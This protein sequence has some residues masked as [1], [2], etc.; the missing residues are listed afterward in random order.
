MESVSAFWVC[1]R[2]EEPGPCSTQ[3]LR[4]LELAK[5]GAKINS[6]HKDSGSYASLQ[7][8]VSVVD[9]LA[10]IAGC[11]NFTDN[12]FANSEENICISKF[13]P[14]VATML[15]RVELLWCRI[16][17]SRR[18]SSNWSFVWPSTLE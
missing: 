16:I 9:S 1:G 7:S 5:A 8:N 17:I 4:L 11:V 15:S 13:E 3:S 18:L 12:V 14:A 10:V 2:S 6:Y